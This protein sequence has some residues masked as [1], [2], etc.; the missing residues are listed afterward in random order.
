M[1]DWDLYD[2][3]PHI[4]H[5]FNL[6]LSGGWEWSLSLMPSGCDTASSSVIYEV[7]NSKFGPEQLISRTFIN[8]SKSVHIQS[9]IN[10]W[11]DKTLYLSEWIPY[12]FSCVSCLFVVVDYY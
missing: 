5:D 10:N 3:I 11:N 12:A 8:L 9:L 2:R 1:K 6:A 4:P 7:Y